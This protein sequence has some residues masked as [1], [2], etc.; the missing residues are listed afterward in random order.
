MS[1]EN[2]PLPWWLV[3]LRRRGDKGEE[4]FNFLASLQREI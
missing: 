4:D 1:F 2:S 3:R